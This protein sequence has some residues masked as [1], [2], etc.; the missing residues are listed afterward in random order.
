M[1]I[2]MKDKSTGEHIMRF[3]VISIMLAILLAPPFT[4]GIMK[5]STLSIYEAGS[6]I[7]TTKPEATF[8]DDWQYCYLDDAT[9]SVAVITMNQEQI[10]L[11]MLNPIIEKYEDAGITI[12]FTGVKE[13]TE[14]EKSYLD[15]DLEQF[16]VQYKNEQS[17]DVVLVLTYLEGLESAGYGD[18]GGYSRVDTHF[19][20][21]LVPKVYKHFG[22]SGV[23]SI[24]THEIAHCLGYWHSNNQNCIMY[25]QFSGTNDEFSDDTAEEIYKLHHEG[26]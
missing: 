15:Y 22:V 18:L 1:N 12:T 13:Y 17:A 21:V 23:M 19:A 9:I 2:D 5:V 3:I 26:A 6:L 20:C 24:A 25:P 16:A 4:Q 11:P 10:T 14:T 7:L 8:P